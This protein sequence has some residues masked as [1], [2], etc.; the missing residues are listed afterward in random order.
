MIKLVFLC[1]YLL[2]QPLFRAVLKLWQKYKNIFVYFLVQ[3]KTLTFAFKIY[4]PLSIFHTNFSNQFFVYIH[5]INSIWSEFIIYN[6][7]LILSKHN[8]FFNFKD[9]TLWIPIFACYG[10]REVFRNLKQLWQLTCT[11]DSVLK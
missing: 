11:Y 8:K 2:F 5:F 9:S 1:F 4:W 7:E 10:S 3:M 6:L